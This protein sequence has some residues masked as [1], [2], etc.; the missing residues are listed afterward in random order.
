MLKKNPELL[1]DGIAEE[2]IIVFDS[3]KN[4]TYLLNGTAA[5]LLNICQDRT[6]KEVIK[7]YTEKY[8]EVCGSKSLAARDARAVCTQLVELGLV[9]DI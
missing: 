2:R 8:G 7:D 5:Y 9:V 4:T 1:V 3:K 6:Q